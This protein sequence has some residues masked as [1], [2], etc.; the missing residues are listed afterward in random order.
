[1]WRASQNKPAARD[2]LSLPDLLAAM[3]ILSVVLLGMMQLYG[4]IRGQMIRTEGELIAQQRAELVAGYGLAAARDASLPAAVAVQP[5]TTGLPGFLDNSTLSMLA[6]FGYQTRHFDNGSAR[7]QLTSAARL[8][9]PHLDFAADCLMITDGPD[10]RTLA[11]QVNRLLEAGAY[12]PLGLAGSGQR[13]IITGP[14]ADS[15]TGSGQT[16]QLRVRDTACLQQPSGQLASSGSE[17]VFPRFVF[18]DTARPA[19]YQRGFFEDPLR[20]HAGFDWQLPASLSASAGTAQPISASLKSLAPSLQAK[21]TITAS[22]PGAQLSVTSPGAAGLS[23]NASASLSL[24]G[25]LDQLNFA[26]ASLTYLSSLSGTD[27]LIFT[28]WLTG[29][30]N[31]TVRYM[32]VRASLAV[33]ISP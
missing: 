33:Q 3:A 7:C 21:L 30:G 14:I 18:F 20:R 32:P 17:L 19:R 27:T 22:K 28:G 9:S 25:R 23:G 1:M 5:M 12:L 10:N 4:H 8:T 16:A 31:Q 13:C 2:G 26:L 24:S 29:T 15:Q 11:Q 6:L